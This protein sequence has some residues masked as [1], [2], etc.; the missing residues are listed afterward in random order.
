MSYLWIGAGIL[1]GVAARVLGRVQRVVLLVLFTAVSARIGHEAW[2]T[3]EPVVPIAVG[4]LLGV[5][6]TLAAGREQATSPVTSSGDPLGTGRR[7]VLFLSYRTADM[8]L[9]RAVTERLLASG[10]GVW[11]NEYEV[12]IEHYD[13]WDQLVAAGIEE[14]SGGIALVGPDYLSSPYCRDE[15]TQMLAAYGPEGVL[16]VVTGEEGGRLLERFPELATSQRVVGH[17]VDTIV[18]QVRSQAPFAIPEVSP[19]LPEHTGLVTG[20]TVLGIPY[21]LD[22]DGW[23]LLAR[24]GGERGGGE[25]EGPQ[26]QLADPVERVL[27]NLYAGPLGEGERRSPNRLEGEDREIRRRTM[28]Q[29]RRHYEA[30]RSLGGGVARGLHLVPHEGW[31]QFAI[32]YRMPGYW[33]RKY[34]VLL[35]QPTGEQAE[36]VF[37]FGV[38]GSFASL[39][40]VASQ[41]DR[42]VTSLAWGVR[43]TLPDDAGDADGAPTAPG[44]GLGTGAG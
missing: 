25:V 18:A 19:C 8:L 23:R 14:A 24:G 22:A 31:G 17:D 34:S 37:T 10:V 43:A 41:M 28:E 6:L 33:S 5:V 40:R 36:F 39:C 27:L 15:L 30:L 1:T 7:R 32:T 4:F 9:A 11:F 2:T 3:G 35:A 42:L 44:L 13:A 16:V 38:V 26:L 20:G 29:A 12:D 21:R